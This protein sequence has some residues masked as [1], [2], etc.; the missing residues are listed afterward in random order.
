MLHYPRIITGFIHAFDLLL[1]P[2]PSFYVSRLSSSFHSGKA[3]SLL[4]WCQLGLFLKEV[5]AW[6]ALQNE[7]Q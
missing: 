5:R 4:F 3:S 1:D 2:S 6:I 7:L